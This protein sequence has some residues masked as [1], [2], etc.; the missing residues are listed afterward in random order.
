MHNPV[1]VT[2]PQQ[3]CVPSFARHN[4]VVANIS[5]VVK[6]AGVTAG[7]TRERFFEAIAQLGLTK[8]PY[9]SDGTI[10]FFFGSD[11]DRDK[12][13]IRKVC[14]EAELPAN[15][16]VPS[17]DR[18]L[19][20]KKV[21]EALELLREIDPELR[22]VMSCIISTLLFAKIKGF[23]G[24]SVSNVLGGIWIGLPNTAPVT[25]FA[26]LLVHELIH[27]CLFLDDMVNGVFQGGEQMLG[28]DSNLV[29]SAILKRK[30]GYDKA[31]HSAF[32]AYSLG[33]FYHQVGDER[34]MLCL[35]EGLDTTVSELEELQSL[36]TDY[37]TQ[38]LHELKQLTHL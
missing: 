5:Q 13:L 10:L 7:G 8:L 3:L 11:S 16:M 2:V 38:L 32:V 33:R 17:E 23:E 6:Y 9:A 14:C 20:V 37:G 19:M 1:A 15:W 30:R 27:N 28:R 12:E 34:N 36:L 22:E 29:T 24:G 4:R 26:A 21:T 35:L 25:E 18:P 31:F